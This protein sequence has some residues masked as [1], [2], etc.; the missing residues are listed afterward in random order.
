MV[1]IRLSRG[2]ALK[3]PFY[4]VMVTDSRSARDGRSIE[5]VGF[6]NPVATGQEVKLKLDAERIQAW[7]AK[8]AQ[9]TEKVKY[10]LKEA[11]KTVAA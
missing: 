5:R 3:R 9:P 4:H 7:I 10:L 2:G 11:A 6:Y 8:G 1:K